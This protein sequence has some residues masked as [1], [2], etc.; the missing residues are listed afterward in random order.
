M[1]IY[2]A[3]F[4]YLYTVFSCNQQEKDKD[5]W[6]SQEEERVKRL[7][8]EHQVSLEHSRRLQRMHQDRN[9]FL[10]QL[11]S[12]RHSEVEKKLNDFNA[13]L[14]VERKKRLA[15]RKEQR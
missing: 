1:D 2:I 7:V 12:A 14:E 15:E 5:F 3:G 11:K 6:Q 4:L 8:E 13:R 9:D 10:E